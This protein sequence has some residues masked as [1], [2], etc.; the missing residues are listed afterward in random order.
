M[1]STANMCLPNLHYS[2]VSPSLDRCR[3]QPFCLL[4]PSRSP[5]LVLQLITADEPGDIKIAYRS[6]RREYTTG[7]CL[8]ACVPI[9]QFNVNAIEFT[10]PG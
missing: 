2:A 8:R 9:A 7:Q 3:T 1:M 6:S 4:P 10:L 5:I